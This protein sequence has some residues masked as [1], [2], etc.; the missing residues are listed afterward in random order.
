MS[1]VNFI[2]AGLAPPEIAPMLSGANILALKKKDGGVRPIAVGE[3]LHRFPAKCAS[4]IVCHNLAN[5]FLPL[6]MGTVK[7]WPTMLG[8]FPLLLK[9]TMFC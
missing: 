4:K 2:L 3:I 6:Q 8:L 9:V 7:Q 1:L 5:Y